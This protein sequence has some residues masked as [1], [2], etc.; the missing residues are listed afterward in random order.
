MGLLDTLMR[1]CAAEEGV[2]RLDTRRALTTTSGDEKR[3]VSYSN[4]RKKFGTT[5]TV[6][7]PWV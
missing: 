2:T 1:T 7:W 4:D 3:I 6:T 5:T